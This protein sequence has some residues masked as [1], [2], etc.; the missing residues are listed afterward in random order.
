MARPVGVDTAPAGLGPVLSKSP[1]R[2]GRAPGGPGRAGAGAA[3]TARGATAAGFPAARY[4]VAAWRCAARLTPRRFD[5]GGQMGGG[6]A[7]GRRLIARC[8]M[9]A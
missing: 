1:P 6:V 5:R 7:R 2:H 8:P 3:A 9:I 4:Q